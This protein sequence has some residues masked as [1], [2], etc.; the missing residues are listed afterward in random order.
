MQGKADLAAK[1]LKIEREL[2]Y[3]LEPTLKKGR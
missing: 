3:D 2:D 1:D